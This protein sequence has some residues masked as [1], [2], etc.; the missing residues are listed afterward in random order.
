MANAPGGDIELLFGPS[1]LHGRS[2]AEAF[3]DGPRMRIRLSRQCE[4][5][6]IAKH[7]SGARGEE[8]TKKIFKTTDQDPHISAADWDTLEAT[9][10]ESMVQLARFWRICEVLEQLEREDP[11]ASHPPVP[12]SSSKSRSRTLPPT[13]SSNPH[14]RVAPAS[15]SSTQTLSFVNVAPRPAKLTFIPVTARN[16]VPFVSDTT[17]VQ[18]Q[19]LSVTGKTAILPTWCRD[20]LELTADHRAPQTKFIP[21]VGWCIRHNSRVSQGGRYKIMFFDGAV[22]EID[23]DED[24]AELTNPAGEMMRC[25]RW[26]ISPGL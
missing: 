26:N 12:L 1:A 9:E 18:G 5:L 7:I 23:V 13:D 3:V 10:Q 2:S 15:L 6:E 11:P 22:L 25:V 16:P 17:S 14:T 4:S 24:W 8:W 20:D 21:S 19:H